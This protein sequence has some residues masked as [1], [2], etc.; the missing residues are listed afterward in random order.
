MRSN[1]MSPLKS[2]DYTQYKA[3][4]DGV[5]INNM[6]LVAE[7]NHYPSPERVMGWTKELGLTIEQTQKVIGINTALKSKLKEMGAAIIKNEQTLDFLFRTKKMDDGT[8]IF[9]TNR[10]GLYQGEMRNAI[11][12]AYFK[13]RGSLSPLQ[14]KKY[15]TL[16]KAQH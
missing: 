3:Y 2:M 11:L 14:I 1:Q 8:L 9:Y 5:D 6:A 16:Q 7:L 12:Q 15:E 4:V 10:Y 13:V